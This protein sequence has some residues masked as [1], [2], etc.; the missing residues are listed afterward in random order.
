MLKYFLEEEEPQGNEEVRTIIKTQL[1]KKREYRPF[2]LECTYTKKKICY[3]ESHPLAKLPQINR[4]RLWQ[5]YEDVHNFYAGTSEETI[6]KSQIIVNIGGLS[7]SIA[8][9]KSKN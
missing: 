9:R 3:C 6:K 7:S 5:S 4:S 8:A 1:I 2:H